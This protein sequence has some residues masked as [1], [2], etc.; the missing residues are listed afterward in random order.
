MNSIL[1]GLQADL[2][3]APLNYAQRGVLKA[4][5]EALFSIQLVEGVSYFIHGNCDGECTDLDLTLLDPVPQIVA[6]QDTDLDGAPILH[7]EAARSS[8]LDVRV[9]MVSCAAEPCSWHVQ[10]GE[11]SSGTLPEGAT[12]AMEVFLRQGV[13]YSL[14]GVCDSDCGDVDLSLDDPSGLTVASDHL[15]DDVPVLLYEPQRTGRS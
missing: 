1:F 11:M 4:G 3:V 10:T 12:D 6:A 13:E 14:Q 8:V 2:G 15:L 7:F 5:G 9:A